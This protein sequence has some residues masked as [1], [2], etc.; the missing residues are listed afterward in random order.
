MEIEFNIKPV[1]YYQYLKQNKFRKYITKKGREYKEE[2]EK[3]FIEAM[4][5]KPIINENCKVDITL[6]F[7]TK[8][9]HDVDNYAKPILDCMSEIIF[10]DDRLVID[11]RVRK[12]Y[13]PNTSKIII[14]VKP[15]IPNTTQHTLT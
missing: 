10:T 13:N 11:L 9:K 4:G 1:S 3:H 8:H 5:D 15:L 6:Y 7:N 14:Y 2:L 12:Y